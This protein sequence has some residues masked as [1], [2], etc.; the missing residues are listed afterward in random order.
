MST[1]SNI[2]LEKNGNYYV[3][4]SHW[5]GYPE[6]NG[7]IL[8]E[9]YTDPEKIFKLIELGDISSL[10]IEIGKKHDFNNPPKDEVNAYHR[11]RGTSWE[12][13][14]Y[15]K[16]DN[17]E[18][19]LKICDN[20][21]TYLFENGQWFFREWD[22]NFKKLTL[23]EC[24]GKENSVEQEVEQEVEQPEKQETKRVEEIAST[25]VTG[26]KLQKLKEALIDED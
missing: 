6:N 7:K 24:G 19:A 23:K 4:Y 3:I 14:T 21:Y 1:H 16:F 2:I 8:L 5:D 9:H 18:E 15:R 25:H 10:G 13:T 26:E 11:D 17:K 22:E 20:D 12:Q